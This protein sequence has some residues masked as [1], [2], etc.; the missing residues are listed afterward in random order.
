MSQETNIIGFKAEGGICINLYV[1]TIHDISF[2]IS[3]TKYEY[4]SRF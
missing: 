3:W 2:V 1:Q 4:W